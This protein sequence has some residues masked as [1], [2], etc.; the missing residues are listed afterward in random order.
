MGPGRTATEFA[1]ALEGE[2]T[3]GK[4]PAMPSRLGQ[5]QQQTGG[6]TRAEADITTPP[7][8]EVDMEPWQDVNA[9]REPTIAPSKPTSHPS[10]SS[11]NG[12]QVVNRNSGY[13]SKRGAEEE[14]G[15]NKKAALPQLACNHPHLHDRTASI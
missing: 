7:V 6:G 9:G 4:E 14:Q 13:G 10:T 1:T 15:T 8:D 12:W 5:D 2:Q 11:N 3:R